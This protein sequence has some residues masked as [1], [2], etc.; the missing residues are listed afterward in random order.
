[1]NN[2]VEFFDTTLRDGEQSPGIN[3]NAKEKVEIA[4]ALERLGIST[5]EAGFPVA[6]PGDFEGVKAVASEVSCRVAALA[7]AV[8]K[9]I[10]VAANALKSAKAPVIHTFIASSPIHM[11]HKLHLKP[12]AIF[13]KAVEAVAMAKSTGARV[14]FS[15]E[16]ATRSDWKFLRELSEAVIEAGADVVN[17]PDT[18]GY[19]MPWEYEKLLEYLLKNVK[20]FQREKDPVLL[21]V[22][23]H[24]D[25]GLAVSNSLTAVKV[26]ARQVEST[27]NG[28]GERAGNAALE[29]VIMAL[30]V[31][32]DQYNVE[33]DIV[34]KRLYQTSRLVSN[35][36]GYPVPRN[37]AV[38]GENAFAHESGIHQDGVLK[39]RTTYEIMTPESVGYLKSKIVLGKHS[40]RHAFSQRVQELGYT[41]DEKELEQAFIKFIELADRKKSVDDKDLEAILST[42][43]TRTIAT[44]ELVN[45]QVLSG[46]DA[47]ALVKLKKQAGSIEP[48][49]VTEAAAGDGAVDSVYK[50]LERAVGLEVS[51]LEYQIGATTAGTDSFGEVMV[52]I[53]YNGQT[54]LGRGVHNDV[55]RASAEAYLQALNRVFSE[56]MH[57]RSEAGGSDFS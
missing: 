24:N 45:M 29:E 56:Q 11:E 33:T 2:K 31:R 52:R 3:L 44:F 39:E 6:S 9:D 50:A 35:L 5:I 19:T 16:D 32:N 21:S 26:G 18:V 40:G 46:E 27:I 49:I 8:P 41:L 48:E 7:R 12:D 1:M 36:T 37:K 25:L 13:K 17:I 20:G 15:A 54:Y 51:L 47:M 55:V 23:C 14:E 4:K 22:H 30:I 10:E 42:E 28:I 53:N 57:D 43:A 38:I 34:T